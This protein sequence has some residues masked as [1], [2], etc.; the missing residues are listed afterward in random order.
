MTAEP[1]FKITLLL[2]VNFADERPVAP[3]PAPPHTE[4]RAFDKISEEVFAVMVISPNLVATEA[5]SSN[6]TRE[7]EFVVMP[8][9]ETGTPT[10]APVLIS[11]VSWAVT[12]LTA[13]IS[14]SPLFDCVPETYTSLNSPKVTSEYC[15][16]DARLSPTVT[17]IAPP[18]AK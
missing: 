6:R 8:V 14:S 12:L 1:S 16:C 5:L 7:V 4:V 13:W 10:K 11:A 9:F 2:L 3:I 17:D 15:D 18:P